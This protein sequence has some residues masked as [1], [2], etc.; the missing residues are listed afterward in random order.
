[1]DNQLLDSIVTDTDKDYVYASK[2]KR[3]LN[4]LIDYACFMG[5]F[6]VLGIVLY[7]VMGEAEADALLDIDPILDRLVTTLLFA[8]Y[9]GF[10]EFA[11]GGK[12]IG[13]LLTRTRAVNIDGSRISLKTAMGRGFSRIVPFEPFSFL[14]S[15]DSGWHDKWTDTKVIDETMTYK[16]R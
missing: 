1:M 16:A 15:S 2:T 10:V 13:K 8:L 6:F 3:L 11:I 9:M 12:T 4:Y 7:T 14:G 5:C